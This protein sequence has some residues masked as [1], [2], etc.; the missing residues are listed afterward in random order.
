MI[1]CVL[2]DS[3][4]HNITCI[5]RLHFLLWL[6]LHSNRPK[7]TLTVTEW[8]MIVK[9]ATLLLSPTA[10][11][12]WTN[13]VSN[14]LTSWPRV[15]SVQPSVKPHQIET[16]NCCGWWKGSQGRW[17]SRRGRWSWRIHWNDGRGCDIILVHFQPH[18]F[19]RFLSKNTNSF[20]K[21][22]FFFLS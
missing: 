8:V 20:K 7:S 17:W 18:R 5:S 2:C 22:Y 19:W 15:K 21:A 10:R 3:L 6:N 9:G 4:N 1:G 14:H 11:R 13:V 12:P 16:K